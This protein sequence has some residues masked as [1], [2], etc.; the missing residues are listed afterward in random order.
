MPSAAKAALCIAGERVWPA[1]CST[2]PHSAVRAVIS[3]LALRTSSRV[4]LRAPPRLS[5]FARGR[6]HCGRAPGARGGSSGGQ[7]HGSAIIMGSKN[8]WDTMRPGRGGARGARDRLRRARH[9]GAPDARAADGVPRAPPRTRASRSSSA[10]PAAAAHL[11]GVTAAHTLLPVLGV[12]ID[13]SALQGLD[14][15][16]ATV[17]MPGGIPVAT[18]AIGKA[19]REERRP[20]RRRHH[21][22]LRLRRCARSSRSSAKPSPRRCPS[23]PTELTPRGRKLLAA[24]L[25][26]RGLQVFPDVAAV[27]RRVLAQHVGGVEGRHQRDAAYSCQV[28]R[29]RVIATSRP[30]SR[31]AAG[32]PSAT[33]TF[34]R[35]AAIWP[36][37][38]G[39]QAAT[40]LGERRAVLGRPA[41]HDVA[42][43]DLAARDPEA[44][45]DHLGQQLAGAADEGQAAGGPPPARAP[46]R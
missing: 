16:L 31:L 39:R 42:D 34:G 21:R 44:L 11:A 18:F 7:S 14:A 8:D 38:K 41:L 23:G 12:P 33:I 3:R 6:L 25:R 37:R 20:L 15:L 29:T 35:T 40:S 17:Q 10:A 4:L 28:P 13:S 30:S 24:A 22:P 1:G 19:G 46:R 5:H 9:L 43:V 36:S 45:L 27:L 26:E 2:M 32:L